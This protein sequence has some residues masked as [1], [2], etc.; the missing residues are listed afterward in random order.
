MNIASTLLHTHNE[1]V[2]SAKYLQSLDADLGP[3]NDVI[4]NQGQSGGIRDGAVVSTQNFSR[5]DM[6]EMRRR[7]LQAHR[8]TALSSQSQSN[9]LF[10]IIR[11]HP[12]EDRETPPYGLDNQADRFR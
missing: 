4:D 7:N 6:L 12:S 3:R 1:R 11:N 9:G 10:G 8:A 5:C 2:V